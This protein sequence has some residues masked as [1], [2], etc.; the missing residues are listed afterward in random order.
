MA[1]ST[2]SK[3]QPV[4]GRMSALLGPYGAGMQNPYT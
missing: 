1:H 4:T 3:A 2:G